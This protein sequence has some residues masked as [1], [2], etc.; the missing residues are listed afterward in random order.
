MQS[1]KSE[2]EEL[3][4]VVLPYAEELLSKHGEFFPFGAAMNRLG[5]ISHESAFPG[6][7]QPPSSE[8]VD[9]LRRAFRS[10]GR[11]G[12]YR[13]TAI[14]YDARV[15]VPGTE[16]KTDAVAVELDHRESYSVVVFFPYALSGGSVEIGSPFAR[17]GTCEIF[18]SA[19]TRGD[20]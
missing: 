14:A 16:S 19:T 8:V 12:D 4:N 13:A 7:E 17:A 3:L 15:Q 5:G 11:S 6:S 18:G 1:A 9:L 10:A 2:A 20:A